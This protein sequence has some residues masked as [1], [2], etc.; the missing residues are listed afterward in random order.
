MKKMMSHI[1]LSSLVMSPAF[2]SR[3]LDNYDALRQAVEKGDDVVAIVHLDQCKAEGVKGKMSDSTVNPSTRV[4]FNLFSHYSV[5]TDQGA[6]E[7]IATSTTI[8]TEHRTFGPVYA[9]ARLRVFQDNTVEFHTA[10]YDPKTYE[11][12]SMVN[13]K[14]FVVNSPETGVVLY[15]K[16]A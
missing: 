14:C 10:Y 8:L 4:N 16:N 1:I 12:K 5:N 15:D 13:Y 11:Q 3:M 7:T 6:K 2:A 9:Y